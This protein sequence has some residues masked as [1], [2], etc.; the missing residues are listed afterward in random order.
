MVV[1]Y[2]YNNISI[3]NEIFE[4]YTPNYNEDDPNTNHFSGTHDSNELD[5]ETRKVTGGVLEW[6]MP[7]S[8]EEL[9][10]PAICDLDPPIG[11]GEVFWEVV[12]GSAGDKVCA[13]DHK[14]KLKWT[15][16]DCVID[17]AHIL[18]QGL[19]FDP[20][21]FFS[22]ITPVDL[23]GGKG[24]ELLIGEQDGVLC[25]T[26]EGTLLWSDKGATDGYYFSS[27]AVCD[28]EGD[29]MGIDADG[30]D[31]GYRDDMEIILGSDNQ[32]NA[33]AF[34]ECWKANGDDVF[35]YE[36]VA[37]EHAFMTCSI[38]T[39]ELDGHFFMGQDHLDWVRENDP[40]T[41]FAD[42]LCSTHDCCGRIWK[43]V[44][45]NTWDQY[46]EVGRVRGH[47]TYSTPAVGN[48]T[49][50][51]EL[52]CI[53][54][55]GS[56]AGSWTT[57]YGVINMY[58]QAGGDPLHVF[59]TGS[60]PSSVFSSPAVCDAQNL[61]PE[62]LDDDEIIE[63]EVYVGCDNGMF[64]C[65]SATD[66]EE[67]WSYKTG[68][69]ILSS[70]AVCNIDSD[71]RLEV[72]IG[73]NDGI[74]Y[75]FEADPMEFDRDGDSH[76][77][78]D[79]IP[80]SGGD[81]GTYDILWMYDTKEVDGATGEIGISS[82]VIGDI[83]RDGVLE[84]LIG[85]NG[86]ILYC[87]N[88]GGKCV[89]G[90]VDWPM[91][92]AD[93]NKTG[94]YRP[95]T[96]FGVKVS[97]GLMMFDGQLVPEDLSKSVRPGQTVSYNLTVQNIGASKTYTDVDTFWL[98]CNQLV[99]KFTD[100]MALH[101][102]SEPV[103]IGEDLKWGYRSGSNKLEPY[104]ILQSMQK[105]NITL[106]L[107]APWSGDLSELCQVEVMAQSENDTY[108]R[109]SVITKTSLEI[110]LDFNIEILKETIKDPED[111]FFGQKVIKV[112]PSDKATV[113]VKVENIGNLNDTYQLQLTGYQIFPEWDAYFNDVKSDIYDNA[114]KLDSKIMEKQFPGVYHGSEGITSFTITA[115]ADAQEEERI[116]LKVLATSGYSTKT[117]F[118]REISK[119]DYIIV[120]VNPIPEL[121]L[122]CRYPRNYV[123]AGGN[124][125]FKVEVVNRG[126]TKI[127]VKLEHSQLEEGWSI[128]F[129]DDRNSS[130]MDKETVVDVIK[131]GVTNVYVQIGAPVT[132][133]AG[134]RQDLIIRGTTISQPTIVSTDSVALTAIV[135][136]FFKIN[137]SFSPKNIFVDPG[138]M[139]ICNITI[140]N[141]G[142]GRDFVIVT[143]TMLEVNWDSTFY[144]G[145]E[146]RVTSQLEWNST[147]EFNMHIKIP[148]EQLAGIYPVRVNISSIGDYIIETCYVTVNQVF[149][150]SIFG[151]EY[152]EITGDKLLNSTI[153]PSPGVAPGATLNFVVEITNHGNDADWVKI[154]LYP[155]KLT[156]TRQDVYTAV[157]W[158]EFDA[159]GWKAYFTGITNSEVY[160]TDLEMKDFNEDIDLSHLKRQVAYLN[161]EDENIRNLN[162]K[163][164]VGQSAWLRV[165]MFVPREVRP[166]PDEIWKF[167]IECESIDPLGMANEA[168]L[169]DNQAFINLKILLP[170]LEVVSK[171]FHPSTITNG[172]II[173]VSAEIRNI[174]DISARD[175]IITFYVDGKEVKS[176]TIS[177]LEIS[178]LRL[179][180]F[181]WQAVAGD[182]EL[183]ISV[184]PE[185]DIVEIREDNNAKTSNVNVQEADIFGVLLNREICS[186]IAV[187]FAIIIF[188]TI[189]L[190]IRKKGNIFGLKPRKES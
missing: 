183:K 128:L 172:E 186:V 18:A 133:E 125:T 49:G 179:I 12:V 86:G 28:L 16:D 44:N 114:F 137:T 100:P 29:Y 143:P 110:T 164:G 151:V 157:A 177:K 2:I 178:R 188:S 112:N 74:V 5:P 66:M 81:S 19:D 107:T 69:R 106:N 94:F 161:E 108:A 146:E 67:L 169:E 162:L 48:F 92:H 82:P 167:G 124:V 154:M 155:L 10:S 135:K 13:V 11:G 104:L 30:N 118:T 54:G 174:G 38:V 84:V 109:D 80:D 141:E 132:A 117:N 8:T 189:I 173:T 34:V 9:S 64:Y 21:P 119:F 102:W 149:D 40:E 101:E 181:T 70:P 168:N 1:G 4:K 87:I 50:G 56:G 115:P 127:T 185:D 36:M 26:P 73:S 136:Q 20:A 37:G 53:V 35:R 163:L 159:L 176:K 111:E 22:S 39:A 3:E 184:D 79:G 72:V 121:E 95:G 32:Q 47:E 116:I 134:D 165:Q 45:G 15:F 68:G 152:S 71:D 75:C 6:S 93:L 17:N 57:S 62:D 175:L 182:H 76:P 85:D 61:D 43:H 89:P 25:L 96:S 23:A 42:F 24:A 190:I 14:G 156:G 97:R 41:L 171:I 105:V 58:N 131:D 31:V 88:A 187:I 78:D 103:L 113:E 180:T 139:I 27:I 160:L 144:L 46:T 138:T 170:D 65:L 122:K 142:N 99:Y 158:S 120:L 55:S 145:K 33:D 83:D 147:I 126:N 123:D 63:Y 90:Q 52:E 153:Q 77:K 7:I 59:A 148:E 166:K 60:G 51:P 130:I 129:L 140:N 150:L 91:F 98:S